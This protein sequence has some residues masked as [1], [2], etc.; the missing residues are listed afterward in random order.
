MVFYCIIIT[1]KNIYIYSNNERL[2]LKTKKDLISLLQKNCINVEESFNSNCEMIISIGGDGTFLR[3]IKETNYPKIPFLGINTGHFGF[4]AEYEP[5]NIDK[6]VN[7]I[8]TGNYILQKYKTIKTIVNDKIELDPAV[9][10]VLIKHNETSVVHLDLYI[11]GERIESLAG[12]GLLISSSAGSTA[13]NYSLG[14]SI[15]DPNIDVLEITPVAAN[16]NTVYR[17]IISSMIVADKRKITVISCDI[18]NTVIVLDGKNTAIKDVKKVE[19]KLSNKVIKVVRSS[20]YSFF[21][22]VKSKFIWLFC[23]R[24]F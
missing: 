6:V 17:S 24:I 1:M 5:K 18:N 2:S 11:D 20:N 4:F 19:I 21:G 13:Y 22:K 15:I 12:D 8:K 9:N 23:R 3:A 10:D 7:D 14:G 16:N